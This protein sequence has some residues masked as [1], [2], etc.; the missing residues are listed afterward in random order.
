MDHSDLIDMIIGKTVWYSNLEY[1]FA[2]LWLLQGINKANQEEKFKKA[3]RQLVTV[4][5]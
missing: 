3:S 5:V 2:R 4:E 1:S